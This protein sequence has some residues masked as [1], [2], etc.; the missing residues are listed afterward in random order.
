MDAILYVC[1][2]HI[3]GQLPK[4][5]QSGFL[6]YWQNWSSVS[7]SRF[8]SIRWCEEIN[9]NRSGKV[10]EI[11]FDSFEIDSR[12]I[13]VK[14]V[15]SF[16]VSPVAAGCPLSSSPYVNPLLYIRVLCVSF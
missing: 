2:V 5:W 7:S 14:Q 11:Q 15:V 12:F 8:D 1:A 6:I 9:L 3:I 13:D 16:T 4:S 10:C